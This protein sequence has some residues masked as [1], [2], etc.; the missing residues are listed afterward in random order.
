MSS[1][2][3]KGHPGVQMKAHHY[4]SILNEDVI[5]CVI[6]DRPR[7]QQEWRARH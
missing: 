1:Y 4:C 3:Y 2:V 7:H 6:L 5:P